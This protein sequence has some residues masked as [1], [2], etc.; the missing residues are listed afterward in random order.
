MNLNLNEI[1]EIQARYY[2]LTNYD[3]DDPGAPIDP[4]T[5]VDSNGDALLH[6]ASAAGDVRTVELLIKAGV[7]ID[8]LGDMDNTALHYAKSKGHEDVA[9][10]LIDHGANTEIENRFGQPAISRK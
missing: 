10:L 5:Y 6:I 8:L 9:K 7:R 3:K 1:A 4:V 2:Y